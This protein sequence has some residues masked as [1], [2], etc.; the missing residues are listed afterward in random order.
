M[1]DAITLLS[2]K[3]VRSYTV[4][5]IQ[6]CI[7]VGCV[8]PAC[9]PQGSPSCNPPPFTAP[10]ISWNPP[11]RNPSQNPPLLM[12][13]TDPAPLW[14]D[15][16]V[17]IT[18]PQISFAGGNKGLHW[19]HWNSSQAYSNMRPLAAALWSC[20]DVLNCKIHVCLLIPNEPLQLHCVKR[21]CRCEIS[22]PFIIKAYKGMD[23][24][25]IE[26]KNKFREN[27]RKL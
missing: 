6:E 13:R 20:S 9:W 27:C 8:P 25:N 21:H 26:Y 16:C 18:L 4:V 3:N 1:K 11:S 10:T 24:Q 22:G 14:T 5:K 15:R 23:H 2:D 19:R 17:H 12:L 7:P